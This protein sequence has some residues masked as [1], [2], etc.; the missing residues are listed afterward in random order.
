MKTKPY[1]LLRSSI[2]N[3]TLLLDANI[4]WTVE[5]GHDDQVSTACPTYTACIKAD[6]DWFYHAINFWLTGS[7]DDTQVSTEIKELMDAEATKVEYQ[8]YKDSVAQI[9]ALP[10]SHKA[11]TGKS[12]ASECK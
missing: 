8:P 6:G 11:H 5:V 7:Q 2:S 4:A 10:K 9:E 1:P 3:G 12:Y